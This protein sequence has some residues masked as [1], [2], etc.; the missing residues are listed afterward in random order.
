[1][2]LIFV[3]DIHFCHG[4]S[5]KAYSVNQDLKGRHIQTIGRAKWFTKLDVVAAF[6]KSR[7]R[8]GQQRMT[9][10]V[11]DSLYEWMVIPFGLANAS[12]TL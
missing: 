8:E 11:Q 10:F 9:V 1:M 7:I 3:Y 2:P 12:S 4:R 5:I 6:H